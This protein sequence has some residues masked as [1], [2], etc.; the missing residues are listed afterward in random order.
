MED[1]IEAYS[2]ADGMVQ[3][4]KVSNNPVEWKYF[5][6]L[7]NLKSVLLLKTKVAASYSWLCSQ[8]KAPH[9]IIKRYLNCI[10]YRK[11]Q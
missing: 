8:W 9:S 3:A 1:N 5:I 7:S 11:Y 2:N 6:D 10:N 4:L